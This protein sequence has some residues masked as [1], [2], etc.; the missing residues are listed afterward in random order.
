MITT[1][2]TNDMIVS[3]HIAYGKNGFPRS[4]TSSL[5]CWKTRRRSTIR[6]L[7]TRVP[8]R[9][10]TRQTRPAAAI[11]RRFRERTRSGCFLR[12]RR[13]GDTEAHDEVQVQPDERGYRPRNQQHVDRVEARQCV[14]VDVRPA[15]QELGYERA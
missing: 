7:A 6:S 5:Y 11:R 9:R 2:T 10:R 15:L 4:L 14:A 12:P 3:C 1:T 8:P 13:G